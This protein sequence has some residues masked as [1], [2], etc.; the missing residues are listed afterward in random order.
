MWIENLN[1]ITLS[2]DCVCVVVYTF[3]RYVRQNMFKS[4]NIFMLNSPHCF[5]QLCYNVKYWEVI[6]YICDK[7]TSLKS[8]YW[9]LM[10]QHIS[11]TDKY[12]NKSLVLDVCNSKMK[13]WKM[14]QIIRIFPSLAFNFSA[15]CP[16]PGT[17]DNG[18]RTGDNFTV[19]SV[20]SFGCNDDYV[21]LG[22]GQQRL[23]CVLGDP[24]GIDW[25]FLTPSCEG[26]TC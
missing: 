8:S 18:Y 21:M 9:V 12:S 14:Y 5:S 23:T 20:V 26:R 2:S 13:D 16:D 10:W 24:D 6:R 19:G 3:P 15:P 11:T 4:V 22:Q 17:P 1:E 7:K 25:N